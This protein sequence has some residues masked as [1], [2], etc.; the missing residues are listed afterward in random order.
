MYG[1]SW[2][3]VPTRMIELMTGSDPHKA[4]RATEAMMT[5][6]KIDI[7]KVEAAAK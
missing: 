2:Q 3:V 6:K 5:M 1:V 7:A 4:Q